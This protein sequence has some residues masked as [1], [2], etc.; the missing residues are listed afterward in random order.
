MRGNTERLGASAWT[1]ALMLATAVVLLIAFPLLSPALADDLESTIS[2]RL[3]IQ[4]DQTPF[5]LDMWVDRATGQSYNIGD[6]VEISAESSRDSYLYIFNVNPRNE[7]F[8]IYP[9]TY[10]RDS[11]LRA[12]RVVRIPRD[13]RYSIRTSTAGTEHLIAIATQRPID[14]N[15]YWLRHASRETLRGEAI[16][17]SPEDFL[18]RLRWTELDVNHRGAYAVS[19]LSFTVRDP[20]ASPPGIL[21]VTTVPTGAS[22]FLDG[23]YVGV[24]P[25]SA[26]NLSNRTYELTIVREG[27]RTLVTNVVPTPGRT[28]FLT[29][30]LDRLDAEW[31]VEQEIFRRRLS[32]SRANDAFSRTFTH[33][34][35]T[36]TLHVR[37][38]ETHDRRL[39]RIEGLL[40]PGSGQVIT[41]FDLR[42]EASTP[43]DR[44]RTIVTEAGTFRVSTT[45]ENL[46]LMDRGGVFSARY[47]REVTLNI[48]VDWIGR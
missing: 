26:T 39:H 5:S 30:T 37:P 35:V 8:L 25:T 2:L 7:V 23:R 12:N 19:L 44:G 1:F 46:E 17:S 45:I 20:F 48:V 47:F 6:S 15:S 43:G 9:N 4:P 14:P 18:R 34:G 3:I 31:P 41:V 32:I 38:V 11:F 22:V 33:M 16:S 40:T 24:T 28:R 21:S 36:A 42:S 13:S 29:Y 27:Y 10:D